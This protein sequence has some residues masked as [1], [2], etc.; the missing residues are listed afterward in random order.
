MPSHMP[1]YPAFK[2]LLREAITRHFA[3]L[4]VELKDDPCFGYSLYTSDDVS[5][6]GPVAVRASA[7]ATVA[8]DSMG[9]YYR[10]S[11]DEW[12]EWEDFGFFEEVNQLIRQLSAQPRYLRVIAPKLLGACADVLGELKDSGAFACCGDDLFLVVW[13]SDSDNKIMESSA[14]KLNSREMFRAFAAEFT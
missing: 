8:G 5:S 11:P 6:I 2:S 14:K 9:V 3:A 13:I 4:V 7:L 10:F 12:S 1:D